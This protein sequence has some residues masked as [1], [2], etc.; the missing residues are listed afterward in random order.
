DGTVA[1]ATCHDTSRGLTD[2]RATSEGI[3]DKIGQRNAPTTMNALFYY[4]QFWDGRAPS[5]E[6]QAKLPIV[7]PIEMGQPDGAAAVAAIQGDP[8]YQRMFEAA[9]GHA[10]GFDDLARAIAAFERT[11]VFLDAPFDRFL[12]GDPKAIDDDAKA[13]WALFH[14][15][16]RCTA[17]HQ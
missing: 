4:T 5:L 14:G 8:E 17:C 9:Y 6:E 15:R 3:G 2:R 1:C 11:L 16:G 12:A 7:N 13:G 10:P